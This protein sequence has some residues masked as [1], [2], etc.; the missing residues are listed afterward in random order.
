MGDNET[1]S[2]VYH[3]KCNIAITSSYSWQSTKPYFTQNALLEN[4][5]KKTHLS[6]DYRCENFCLALLGFCLVKD[7]TTF[8]PTLNYDGNAVKGISCSTYFRAFLCKGK[9]V[10]NLSSH[11]I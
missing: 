11:T 9:L 1:Q 3:K 2:N 6:S 10:E 7:R 5:Q 8:F 4:M